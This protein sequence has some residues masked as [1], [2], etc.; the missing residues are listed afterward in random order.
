MLG[1]RRSTIDLFDG[2]FTLITGAD[3]AELAGG[4]RGASRPSGRCRCSAWA[5]SWRTR[6]GEL[7]ARYRLTDRGCVLVRPDGYVAWGSDEPSAARL[8]DALRLATGH[9]VDELV[10]LKS[11]VESPRI[12]PS[13][14]RPGPVTVSVGCLF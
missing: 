1:E 6:L 4:G 10:A 7:A 12:V 14:R 5:P 11:S 9:R 8:Q 2:H 3:G 13:G